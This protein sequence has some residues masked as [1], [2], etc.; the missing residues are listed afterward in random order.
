MKN[1][2]TTALITS[3]AAIFIFAIGA[4]ILPNAPTNQ[5][6]HTA[7]SP[8]KMRLSNSDWVEVQTQKLQNQR[9]IQGHLQALHTAALPVQVEALTS[10]VFVR[11]GDFVHKNQLLAKLD[12]SQIALTN[13]ERTAHLQ[14]AKSKLNLAKQRLD[15]QRQLFEQGFISALAFAEFEAE[16]L[17]QQAQFN[18]QQAQLAQ[19][20]K[21]LA[22]SQLRAPFDGI[23]A[24]RNLE[25]GQLAARN[26]QAFRLL[27]DR[28]LVLEASVAARDVNQVQIGQVI[29]FQSQNQNYQ[30]TIQRISPSTSPNT[31]NMPIF[32]HI[33][34]D[35]RRLKVGQFVQASLIFAQKQAPSLPESAIRDRQNQYAWVLVIDEKTQTLRRQNIQIGLHDTQNHRLEISGLALGTRVIPPTVLGLSAGQ[36]VDAPKS[37][38]KTK[39]PAAAVLVRTQ[40]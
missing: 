15:R 30:A 18:A 12:P 31:R 26:S 32:A 5:P 21:D 23:I 13:Q 38:A 37:L 16:F 35:D 11:V 40:N 28:I 17:Q 10:Q 8:N 20:Q 14:A 25:E 24:E 19:S 4:K 34:N 33:N 22:D 7:T 36:K 2:K 9:Q 29:E 27:D 6:E 39:T 3:L 1:W